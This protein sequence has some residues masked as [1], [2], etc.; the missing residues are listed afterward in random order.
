MVAGS[1]LRCSIV[2]R[3]YNESRHIGRLLAGIQQQTV[4][5]V[6]VIL[7]DSGSTDGTVAIAS[8]HGAR[9]VHIQP[10]EFTFGKSLNLGVETARG[11][12]VVIASA[13]VYP[14]YEDWLER[15]LAPFGDEKVALSY[16]KQRGDESSKFS[17]R[18]FLATWFPEQSN[19]AQQ[20]PF[21]NNANAAIRRE[22]WA[23]HPYDETLTGLEDLAWAQWVMS[24][25]WAIAYVAEAEVIHVH[26]E[27]P[28]K[29]YNRYRREAMAFKRIYPDERFGILDFFRLAAGNI[30]SD[31]WHAARQRVLRD[32][33]RT[34]LWFRIMQ[35][36]GTYRGYRTPGPVTHQL[37]E[38][39]YYPRALQAGRTTG[40]REDV[41][42]VQYNETK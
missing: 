31:W 18:Q 12:L 11:P 21:C 19:P 27:P 16:G 39:F 34:I 42:P 20:N 14:V 38:I 5:N 32:H 17:E 4:R 15:L 30:M 3:A 13:H 33:W 7:V 36:W 1:E 40:R 25:G 9:V 2:I 37:R 8:R 26:H 22:L 28:K 24:Q 41:S 6:E 29:V 10:E 23:Q 35:F